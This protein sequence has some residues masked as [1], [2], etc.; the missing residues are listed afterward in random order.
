MSEKIHVYAKADDGTG[1]CPYCDQAKAWLT[2][3]Q[4]PFTVEYLGPVERN[5][6]YDRLE[7]V[8]ADRTV[9][10]V[11]ITDV[12]GE[13]SRIGGYQALVAFKPKALTD[14]FR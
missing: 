9:P 5:A 7:L 14:L 3:H 10:Q 12:G 13:T 1:P 2:E 11:M 6:L 4:I 8:G